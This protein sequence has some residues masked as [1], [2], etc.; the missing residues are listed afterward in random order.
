MN[1]SDSTIIESKLI[2]VLSTFTRQEW[3]LFKDYEGISDRIKVLYVHLDRYFP[4]SKNDGLSK[5]KI[6][7]SVFGK[8]EYDDKKLR[9]LLTEMLN[10]AYSF[11]K[12]RS[13][14]SKE[15][16]GNTLLLEVL[17][18][19]GADKAY[20]GLFK[21]DDP[22]TKK[23]APGSAEEY[24][25]RYRDH[26]THLNHFVPRQPRGQSNIGETARYLD[27]Y[28][29][30]V[31]LQLL[32]E[33]INVRNVMEVNY[34]SFLQQEIITALHN[35]AFKNIPVVSIY[36]HILM[37]LTGHEQELHAAELEKIL[38][39]SHENFSR[40]EL[41]EMYQYLMNFCIRKIN[42]G[43]TT[44][45]NRLFNI[46]KTILPAKIIFD[47]NY[48]SQWDYKNIVVIGL[49]ADE[50]KWVEDFIEMYKKYLPPAETENA[51]CY[52]MAYFHFS[53]GN[54]K[55]ALG[56]LQ[57]VEF[58]DLYYQLDMR[59]ILLK[60]YYETDE[61]E[62]LFYHLAAFRIFLSRNKLISDYQRTIYRNMIRYT[63]AIARAGTNTK[64]LRQIKDEVE[65]VRQV[66][67]IN[68]LRKKIEE[69]IW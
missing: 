22:Q 69:L 15:R 60:C 1:L 11:L 25:Y 41:R 31:K 51:Y 52:N 13:L 68:W 53:T 48:L 30:A 3:K 26:Y 59:A 66:A 58:T 39:S 14:E 5:Y 50:S 2:K 27:I 6:F 65:S 56:L 36:Y 42:T 37:T 33:I 20:L 45:L 7:H 28:Y 4:F 23:D 10:K 29:L 46:Y 21:A 64:K 16:L 54:H 57:Q 12:I 19:R 47:G 44:Y 8:T 55:K 9:Y 43:D 17:A 35:G 40:Q 67:D 24:Y 38:H 62:T 49:R 61:M 18:R 32:C 34:D 63:G